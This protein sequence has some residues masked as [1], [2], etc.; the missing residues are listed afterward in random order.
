MVSENS[1]T[2]QVRLKFTDF[3]RANR[4]YRASTSND[5]I[6]RLLI[7]LL[8][9]FL[10]GCYLVFLATQ[11]IRSHNDIDLSIPAAFMSI[12]IGIILILDLIPLAFSWLVFKQNNRLYSEPYRVIFDE[13][14]ISVQRPD[15]STKYEWDLFYAAVE[16]RDEFILIYGKNLYFATP[17]TCFESEKQTE[18]FRS[19]L[20]RKVLS[21]RQ[22]LKLPLDI[23]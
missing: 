1:I 7:G 17:K 23:R 2:V 14:G 19:I 8:S 13:N 10:G 12:L 3:W 22:M 9:L 20:Q 6:G 4:L 15:M 11:P 5:H 21:F 16:G 18:I